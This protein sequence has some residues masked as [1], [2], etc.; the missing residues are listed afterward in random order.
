MNRI[1]NGR[2][3]GWKELLSVV[4]I[5]IILVLCGLRVSFLMPFSRIM[6]RLCGLIILCALIDFFS[7]CEK[8]RVVLRWF[9]TYSLELYVLHLLLFQPFKGFEIDGVYL[10]S[11]SIIL[12]LLLCQPI[13]NVI[14]KIVD[15][16]K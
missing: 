6:V 13:H 8:L 12:S 4:V 9:G 16:W 14:N 11:A 10:I 5:T 15:L 1:N 7:K 3:V 2:K